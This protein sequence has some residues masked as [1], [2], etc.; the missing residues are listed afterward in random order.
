[1][2]SPHHEMTEH[3]DFVYYFVEE[4]SSAGEDRGSR[5]VHNAP[6]LCTC[7]PEQAHSDDVDKEED[8]RETQNDELS[9]DGGM[10][11]LV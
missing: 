7:S 10:V 11:S 3:R 8:A 2:V 1:M 4:V 9:L 6:D 5:S